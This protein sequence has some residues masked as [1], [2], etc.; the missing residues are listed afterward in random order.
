MTDQSLF[1]DLVPFISL[2]KCYTLVDRGGVR[3]FLHTLC[4]EVEPTY[5]LSSL[6]VVKTKL[7]TSG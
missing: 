3:N 2:R 7:T 5:D 6:C 4:L 1:I